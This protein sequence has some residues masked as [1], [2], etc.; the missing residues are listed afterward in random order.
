MTSEIVK[1]TILHEPAGTFKY[2]RFKDGTGMR[3]QIDRDTG[4]IIGDIEY[5]PVKWKQYQSVLKGHLVHALQ[6]KGIDDRTSYV[7][8]RE[9]TETNLDLYLGYLIILFSNREVILRVGDYLLKD[10]DGL[11]WSC[12]KEMF[13]V[14]YR[15][16]N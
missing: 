10:E 16:V 6:W 5:L 8:L 7:E 2:T 3:H 9:F 12:P 11:V 15:E 13:K 1:I 14:L 4:D